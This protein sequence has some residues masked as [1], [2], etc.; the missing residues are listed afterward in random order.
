M[1]IVIVFLI[2]RLYFYLLFEV[3]FMCLIK[4]ITTKSSARDVLF[5]ICLLVT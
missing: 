2:S 5:F 4:Y 1:T 3:K